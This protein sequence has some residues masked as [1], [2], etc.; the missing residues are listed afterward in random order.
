MYNWGGFQHLLSCYWF[1]HGWWL[2]PH[3]RETFVHG[4]PGYFIMEFLS[5]IIRYYQIIDLSIQYHHEIRDFPYVWGKPLIHRISIPKFCFPIKQEAAGACWLISILWLVATTQQVP[6][7]WTF[8]TK[9]VL[10]FGHST[11]TMMDTQQWFLKVVDTCLTL[12]LCRL[13]INEIFTIVWTPGAAKFGHLS[14]FSV[15]TWSF[16]IGY[17]QF[18]TCSTKWDPLIA[19][20]VYNTNNWGLW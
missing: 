3:L 16:Y 4:P 9:P 6:F 15:N 5:N 2:C 1:L 8:A 7:N 17:T 20:F 19:K 18:Q 10:L 13:S 14:L 11:P 12:S